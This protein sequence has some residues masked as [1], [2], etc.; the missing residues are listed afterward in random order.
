MIN[1][2]EKFIATG[3]H[4]A[5]TMLLAAIAAALIFLVW[6]PDPFQTIVGG[7]GLF[8]LVVGCDL[9][10]GPLLSLVIYD[11]RKSRRELIT[12]YAVVGAVQI[13]ALVYG[14][15]IVAGTRPV[16]V[17]FTND[18]YEVVTARDIEPEELAAARS[19]EYA[20]LP[21]TGPRFIAIHVPE[22]ERNDA[23]FQ[24]L[25]GKEEQLRPKFYVAL[26]S[27]LEAIRQRAQPFADLEA[28][29]PES[30]EMIAEATRDAV[31]ANT[32]AWLPLRYREVFWTAIVDTRT[33]LPVAYIPLDPY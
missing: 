9:A 33:G 1:W 23:L 6:F 5:V 3:I 32:L 16:Y 18:R 21:W 14:V 15:V 17:A 7:T 24:S 29:K 26:E 28:R 4:F 2:R 25:E 13:A 19:P 31:P 10:L 27:E 30:K 12:D 11:S 22:A 8:L 20:S